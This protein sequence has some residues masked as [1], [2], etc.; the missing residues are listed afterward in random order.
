LFLAFVFIFNLQVKKFCRICAF[1]LVSKTCAISS[2]ASAAAA[3][4]SSQTSGDLKAG[5]VLFSSAQQL[6]QDNANAVSIGSAVVPDSHDRSL[7]RN[8]PSDSNNESPFPAPSVV[9][10]T[11]IMNGQVRSKIVH[12]Q[13]LSS[14]HNFSCTT[15]KNTSGPPHPA[16]KSSSPA[17]S[18]RPDLERGTL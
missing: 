17:P 5:M 9:G 8:S 16:S 11:L 3:A 15:F 1:I 14:K 2:A 6:R 18:H 12:M 7:S 13:P 10:D 4:S